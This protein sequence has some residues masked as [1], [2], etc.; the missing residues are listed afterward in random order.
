MHR[1]V[2]THAYVCIV[3]ICVY[4]YRLMRTGRLAWKNHHGYCSSSTT[5]IAVL[6]LLL[7]WVYLAFNDFFTLHNLF[8]LN[9]HLNLD[10]LFHGHLD[11]PFHGFD[12]ACAYTYMRVYVRAWSLRL[13]VSFRV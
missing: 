10:D 11:D 13:E 7:P 2:C 4:V 3:Y 5:M 1:Y 6:L 8:P 9:W 12:A